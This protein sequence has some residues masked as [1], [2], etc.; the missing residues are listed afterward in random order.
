MATHPLQHQVLLH[1]RFREQLLEA[2]PDAGAE[3]LADTLEGLTDLSDQLAAVL[4]SA[5]DVFTSAKS[6]G[7]VEH[8]NF[9][10]HEDPKKTRWHPPEPAPIIAHMR[11]SGAL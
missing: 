9:E 5:L 4:R 1:R 10:W 6:P 11:K 3:T 2:F 7:Q 8:L